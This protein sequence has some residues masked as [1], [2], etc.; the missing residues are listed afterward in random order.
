MALRGEKFVIEPYFDHWPGF[1][2]VARDSYLAG[3]WQS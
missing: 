3:Y 1:S 2:R